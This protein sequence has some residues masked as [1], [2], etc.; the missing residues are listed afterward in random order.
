MKKQ[1]LPII[2]QLVWNHAVTK[3]KE[4]MNQWLVKYTPQDLVFLLHLC[5]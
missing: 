3:N 1:F 2:H 5:N 4:E